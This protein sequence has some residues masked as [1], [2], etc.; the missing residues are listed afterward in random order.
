MSLSDDLK[1]LNDQQSAIVKKF[2]KTSLIIA[3]PGTGKTR[4]I[5]VLIG[6]LLHKGT[7]LKEILALT[8]S[9]K[10]ALELRSRVLEYYRTVLTSAGYRRFT[11]SAP[12]FY[13]SNIIW[14][15]LSLT[16]SY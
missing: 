1:R 3:G 2:G 12:E 7:R 4:T 8:F 10:A 11:L 9:D 16:L 6:D 14:Y 13:V 5:S 15:R